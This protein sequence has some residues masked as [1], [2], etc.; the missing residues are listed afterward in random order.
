MSVICGN[1]LKCIALS[2][3]LSYSTHVILLKMGAILILQALTLQGGNNIEI[4]PN[5]NTYI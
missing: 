4:L 2:N 3:I 1:I 5:P